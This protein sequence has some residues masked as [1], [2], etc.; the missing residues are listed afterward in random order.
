[1]RHDRRGWTLGA[2]VAAAAAAA[3]VGWSLWHESDADAAQAQLWAS[4]FE[5]PNGPPLAMAAF[6]GQALLLNFWATWCPPCVREMPS[7]DRFAREV[8]ARGWR[9][10]GLAADNLEP[11][12][13]FLILR[14]VS[15]P[16]GLTGFA[17]IELSRRLGNAAGGLP[18]TLLIGRNGRVLER[19]SGE[20]K[21][22]QL[23]AWAVRH[24]AA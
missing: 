24:G 10:V 15:Y 19:H 11:V 22:D 13:E 5:A 4:S 2:G 23:G 16:V 20:I 8:A 21:P 9:V 18:F 7:L 12:R 3:G 17:G 14:P 1:M 6:R